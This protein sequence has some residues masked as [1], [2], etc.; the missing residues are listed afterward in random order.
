MTIESEY[1]VTAHEAT[2]NELQQES[3]CVH[4]RVLVW[5]DMGSYL[6]PFLGKGF[7]PS[8]LGFS[9]GYGEHLFLPLGQSLSLWC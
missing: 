3:T 4:S 5:L 6:E 1:S 7:S 9:L 8:S 2:N